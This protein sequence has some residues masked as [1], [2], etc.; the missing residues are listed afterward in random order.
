M[1][2]KT[3]RTRGSYIG[4]GPAKGWRVYRV[5]GSTLFVAARIK[6]FKAGKQ[7]IALFRIVRTATKSEGAPPTAKASRRRPSANK[8]KRRR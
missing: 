2:K 5:G 4:A 3:K 6:A 7:T 8:Y 1:S